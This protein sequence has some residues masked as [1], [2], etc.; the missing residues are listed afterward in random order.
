MHHHHNRRSQDELLQGPPH[1]ALL[2]IIRLGVTAFTLPF[3]AIGFGMLFGFGFLGF[4]LFGRPSDHATSISLIGALFGL[5]F[6]AVPAIILAAVW[7]SPL[8]RPAAPHTPIPPP[9]SS[10][11]ST[12]PASPPSHTPHSTPIFSCPYC[13]RARSFPA[14]PCPSCGA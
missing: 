5:P 13:G 7:L 11:P 12:P 1:T 2:W 14:N 6:I 10:N 4:G 8:R 9:P 3:F